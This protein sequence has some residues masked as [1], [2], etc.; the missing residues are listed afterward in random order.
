[1]TSPWKAIDPARR[2]D[3]FNAPNNGFRFVGAVLG[4]NGRTY[5]ANFT[6]IA[7]YTNFNSGQFSIS[8]GQTSTGAVTFQVPDRV[9]VA[10]I[11]W[12]ATGGFGGQPAEWVIH[13]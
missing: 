9:T 2:A 13:Y 5:Q 10:S 3:Q 1:M 4:S 11:Q 8:T 12:D 7:G 6:S